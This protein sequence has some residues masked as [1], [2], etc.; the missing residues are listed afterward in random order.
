[1]LLKVLNSKIIM[2]KRVYTSHQERLGYH[3]DYIFVGGNIKL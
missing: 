1:M 2:I 3:D